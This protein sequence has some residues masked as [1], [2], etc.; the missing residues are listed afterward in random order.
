MADGWSWEGRERASEW[1][2]AWM[3]EPEAGSVG[4]M[5]ER[6]MAG[7]RPEGV[8]ARTKPRLKDPLRVRRKRTPAEIEAARQRQL[9]NVAGMAALDAHRWGTVFGGPNMPTCRRCRDV[10]VTGVGACRRHGGLPELIARRR[11]DPEWQPRRL[12][13]V[14]RE[15]VKALDGG[16]IPR[17][18]LEQPV[19]VRAA[20]LA[21]EK[22]RDIMERLGLDRVDAARA[23]AEGTRTV[24]ELMMAWAAYEQGGDLQPWARAASRAAQTLAVN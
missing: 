21:T 17:G 10:A 20:R 9:A 18:L 12:N 19:F 7:S 11:A 2:G 8:R 6:I 13:L 16:T 4:A 15:L 1:G 24:L 3:A 14:R 5:V 22:P 23:S